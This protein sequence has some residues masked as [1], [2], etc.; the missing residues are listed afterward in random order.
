VKEEAIAKAA[1]R[2][3]VDTASVKAIISVESPKGAF[4]PSGEPPVLFERHK[5]SKHTQGRYDAKYPDISNPQWG[6]YGKASEQ[7]KRLQKAAAL[8]REAALKSASFGAF[9]ILG[10]NYAQAGFKTVQ[11][12]VNA[13]YESEEAQL[14]AFVEFIRSDARLLTALRRKDWNSFAR[15]YNG[16]AYATHGYHT[17]LA[18]AYKDHA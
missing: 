10:E 3:G 8:D 18:D 9:Q 14:G 13:M 12:F 6:G 11:D 4:L 2:L 5:F 16:P 1:Q 7:H 15:Y 17:R